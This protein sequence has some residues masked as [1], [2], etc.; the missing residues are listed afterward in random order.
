MD[1]IKELSPYGHWEEDVFH[2]NETQTVDGHEIDKVDCSQ[3]EGP[4][5]PLDEKELAFAVLS[6]M[7][8]GPEKLVHDK[9]PD[10]PEGFPMYAA[11]PAG[12]EDN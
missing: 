9:M 3:A 10:S 6:L 11:R 8:K 1:Y 2:F 4:D 7:G 5:G 12:P